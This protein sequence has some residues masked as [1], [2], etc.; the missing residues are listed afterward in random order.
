MKN[1]KLS[2]RDMDTLVNAHTI[3]CGWLNRMEDE[4]GKDFD[5]LCESYTYDIGSTASCALIEFIHE[6]RI[7]YLGLGD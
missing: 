5:E 1:G 7:E 6:Y 2:Q 3:I 4:T